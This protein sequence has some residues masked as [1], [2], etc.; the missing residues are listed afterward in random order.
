MAI[1]AETNEA[2]ECRQCCAFCDKVIQPRG[3][4]EMDCPFLY[5]YEDETS[6]RSYMGCLQKVFGVEI[7]VAMFNKAERTRQGFGGVKAMRTP[8]ATCPMSVE[9]SYEGSGPAFECVNLRFFDASD[10]GPGSYRAF[11]LRRVLDQA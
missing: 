7:D 3:C 11:D 10:E 1:R 5:T 8:L 9:R 2:T 4:V 6:G